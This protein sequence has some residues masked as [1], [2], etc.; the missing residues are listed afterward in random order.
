MPFRLR[1]LLFFFNYIIRLDKE[2][3]MTPEAVRADHKKKMSTFLKLIDFQ[4]IEMDKVENLQIPVR[5]G[6]QIGARLYR[7]SNAEKL[8]LMVFYHGGGFVTRDLDSHDYA[9]RRIAKTS[10]VVVLSIDYRLAPEFKF[11]HPHQDCYDA[12]VWAS[13][14]ASE[15]GGDP[16]KLIVCGDSAGG[17]LSTVVSI[18]SRD[19][20]G[21]KVWKQ[22][23]IYPT[24][25]ARMGFPSIKKYSKG[26]FLTESLMNWFVDHYARTPE[27]KLDPL[28]SPYLTDEL[29]NLP[30]AYVCTAEFDPLRD[31]GEAYAKR[32]KDAGNTVQFKH[33]DGMIHG[34]LNLPKVTRK[35]TMQLHEEIAQFIAS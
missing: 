24:T 30:P 1:L 22:V 15:L 33:F 34:F 12:L 4:P 26:Y 17:N 28:M 32:L 5:D 19:Q 23:L 6:S 2:T 14:Q 21:P 29:S 8:P 27:D 16:D 3:S 11:P 35:S 13:E 31:E 18:L 20:K 7:P 10:N 9:C 25:D